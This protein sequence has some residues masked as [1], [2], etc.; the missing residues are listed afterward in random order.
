MKQ[1][2]TRDGAFGKPTQGRS[3]T[4]TLLITQPWVLVSLLQKETLQLW[5]TPPHILPIW[6]RVTFSSFP[7]SNL[8]W[9]E[10]IFLT[11]IPSKWPRRRSLKR[12]QKMPSKG[13][14]YPRK[15]ECTSVSKWKEITLKEFDFGI[16]QYFSIQ[17]L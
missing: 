4:I 17:F 7:R 6:P 10:P 12:F 8:F 15:G 1:C 3:I 13:V 16:F 9:K 5:N 14:L 11:S 2:V